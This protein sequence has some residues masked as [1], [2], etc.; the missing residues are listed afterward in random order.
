MLTNTKR[1]SSVLLLRCIYFRVWNNPHLT[2][3]GSINNQC[4]VISVK[5]F[6]QAVHDICSFSKCNNKTHSFSIISSMKLYIINKF[7][8][9]GPT[10]NTKKSGTS[11]VKSDW[12]G[13]RGPPQYQSPT[14]TSDHSC[15]YAWGAPQDSVELSSLIWINDMIDWIGNQLLCAL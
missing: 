11:L 9:R 10:N 15:E 3:M 7:A 4:K 14:P 2:S 12:E 8:C 6:I 13:A 5:I 1:G